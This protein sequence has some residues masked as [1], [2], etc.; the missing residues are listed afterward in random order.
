MGTPLGAIARPIRV[1]KMA[2]LVA[3]QLRRQIVRREL[4]AGAPLPSEAQMMERF[5]VS[6]PTLREAIRVLESEA[7]I[8][9][10]RGP[11]G[12]AR[13]SRPRAEVAA[14]YA[15]LILQHGG[16]TLA[17]VM[18]MRTLVES[19]AVALVARDHGPEDLARLRAA[20]ATESDPTGS[21]ADRLYH[22]GQLHRLFIELTRNETLR[23]M[24][25]MI[26]HIIELACRSHLL[27]AVAA[28]ELAPAQHESAR[29][30]TR[31]VDLVEK[32]DA[33]GAEELWREHL[34][35]ANDV[36]PG[37]APAGVLDVLGG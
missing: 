29:T 6:R 25:D 7:L 28:G 22:S 36:L 3:A 35:S 2:E 18:H 14:R 17:D 23:V 12:G 26:F 9:V 11:G 32:R 27:P 16:T 37:N 33:V 19:R 20:L 13:V 21:P 4:A 34:G 15:G 30:H 10:R 24:M 5:E 31:V 8:K 1:P